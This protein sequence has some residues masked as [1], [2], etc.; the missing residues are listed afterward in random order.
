MIRPEDL[1]RL[2]RGRLFAGVEPGQLDDLFRRCHTLRF[3]AGDTVLEAGSENRCLY[4]L[5][6]GE[7]S[8]NL[9][10]S[11]LQQHALFR[12][13]DCVGELSLLDGLPV[14]AQVVAT[15]DTRVLVMPHDV[16]WA[17]VD[18][19]HGV[20]RNL[21]AILA[22]RMRNDN[23]ALL[24]SH[25]REVAFEQAASIDAL[26]GVHNRR[27]LLET[28]PRVLARASRE[29]TAVS[30]LIVDVDH[31]K[32]F[33]DRHG[34][35]TGDDVLRHMARQ[36]VSGLRAHDLV[37]RYGGEEFLVLLPDTALPEAVAAIHRVR[38]RLAADAGVSAGDA[39]LRVTFSCGAAA[40]RPGESLE[41]LLS[42]A[43]AALLRAKEGGRDRV[44][45]D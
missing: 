16:L 31:F 33:N 28:F 34:H 10:E 20:A 26:T 30:L 36:L 45:L 27:W 41:D 40:Q 44:E 32:Q 37:A 5:I 29:N 25:A 6:E 22:G 23:H 14:S 24:R 19:S 39:A 1:Q 43:D 4:V 8:V 15:R 21:L 42:R 9:A 35:Q 2:V 3:R 18:R 7:V 12:D 11:A 13:G 17:L 38:A